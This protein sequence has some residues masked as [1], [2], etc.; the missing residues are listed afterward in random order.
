LWVAA[1]AN[2]ALFFAASPVFAQIPAEPRVAVHF[3]PTASPGKP[4]PQLG[5]GVWRYWSYEERFLDLTKGTPAR[6]SALLADGSRMSWRDLW[7]AGHIDK[8]TLYPVS[9]PTGAVLVGGVFRFGADTIPDAFA[10]TYVLD[11]DGDADL[12][13]A[14]TCTGPSDTN[15][16]TRI[17][18]NR[19][20]ASLSGPNLGLWEITR[21]GPGGVRNIRLYRKANE[22]AL[23]RGEI[24][25]PKF[26]EHARRYKVLRF[27]DPQDASSARPFR[28]GNF[29]TANAASYVAELYD[30]PP[31]TP[32]EADHAVLFKVALETDTA[33]WVHVAALPGAPSSLNAFTG[34][35]VA[36]PAPYQ[37]AWLAACRDTGAL[38]SSLD[39]AAYMD[40][41]VR[42]L[43]SSGY[44]VRRLLYLE[45]WNEVWNTAQPWDRM[46]YCGRGV[47]EALG[48]GQNASYG[49]GYLTA[50]MMVQMDAALKRANRRQAWTVVLAQ[51]AVNIWS[52]RGALA[53]FKRYF[54]DRGVDPAP[55]IRHVGVSVAGYYALSLSRVHG[56]M[57]N[58][59]DQTHLAA[60]KAAIAADPAGTAKARADWLI[61]S[62]GYGS[63]PW[64]AGLRAMHEA[65][66]VAA[67]A[68]FLG[69]FEGESYDEP[70]WYMRGDP[71]IINWHEDFVA[72]AEGER[73]TRA[74]VAAMHA[75]N[76]KAIAA[77]YLS[78]HP[79]DPEG[80]DPADVRLLDPWW[81]G[82][83]GEDNGRTRGLG[84][85]L[86]R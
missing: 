59:D 67:G 27:M 45:G 16:Q 60:L 6:Y 65:E 74:W 56:F 12:R 47:A 33:A 75:Q 80:S 54:T 4:I 82:Y 19:V 7:E 24:L 1:I 20:E 78:I 71:A 50:H 55:W 83:Y 84:S 28:P 10:D 86:R 52:T 41:I 2:A 18:E 15:C 72:G 37:Q 76:P 79:F 34:P 77:N 48:Q 30:G 5:L 39:W 31:E 66:A 73:V 14:R 25:S 42:G 81:D 29:L 58:P 43:R 70:E 40:N 26:R 32:R 21:I 22:A 53:G 36:D 51:Q 38:L 49:Y 63:I 69:D 13:L 57:K 9:L 44:P 23:N 62:N 46:S 3:F 61:S 11:W 68:Y 8:T 85:M 35:P 17:S 64:A